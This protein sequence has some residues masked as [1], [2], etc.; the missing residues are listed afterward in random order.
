MNNKNSIGVTCVLCGVSGLV[1]R[2]IGRHF[3]ECPMRH[4]EKTKE[5]VFQISVSSPDDSRYFLI[6]EAGETATLDS[7][8]RLLRALWLECCGHMS[9]FNI[10]GKTK[11]LKDI[12]SPG[13]LFSYEY[14]FGS[15]TELDLRVIDHT[16]PVAAGKSVRLLARNEPIA[17]QCTVCGKD[18]T[19]LCAEC[20]GEI[21]SPDDVNKIFFCD[22]CAQKHGEHTHD[23][24]MFLPVVNS[25]RMGVCGYTG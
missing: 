5:K 9:Q 7:V 16:A 13:V 2:S 19:T 20:Q 1:K 10:G 11:K 4:K 21:D 6:L 17:I 24:E 23:E 25:P 22:V 14:D 15:T 12:L 3:A 18:A 8:D